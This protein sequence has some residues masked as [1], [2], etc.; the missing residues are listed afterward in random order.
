MVTTAH[1]FPSLS[2]DVAANGSWKHARL[3]ASVWGARS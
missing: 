1:S 3:D 2:A